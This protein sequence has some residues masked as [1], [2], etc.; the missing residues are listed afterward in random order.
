MP[1]TSCS[2]RR[3]ASDDPATIGL[4]CAFPRSLPRCSGGPGR[5]PWAANCS[6]DVPDQL[7]PLERCGGR[8]HEVI[9]AAHKARTDQ[10]RDDRLGVV[11]LK[12][13]ADI[14]QRPYRR[15]ACGVGEQV[16]A[17][18]FENVEIALGGGTLVM[19]RK[20][21][22]FGVTAGGQFAL[23]P[24]PTCM[25]PPTLGFPDHAVKGFRQSF[26]QPLLVVGLS[27]GQRRLDAI[28]ESIG[29]AREQLLVAIEELGPDFQVDALVAAAR[30]ADARE[31][32]K[33]AVLE[34]EYE[35]LINWMHELAARALAEGQRLGVL[36]GAGGHPWEQLAALGVISNRSAA[37]LQEAKELRDELAHAYPPAGWMALY[38]GIQT[39]L[40][41]L[42]RYMDRCR[43]WLAEAGILEEVDQP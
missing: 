19:H 7:D 13:P 8:K 34:R 14:R 38:E 25:E 28:F 1:M 21:Q 32:N 40:A 36:D 3:T 15:L 11:R 18:A 6:D 9:G 30:S 27:K 31:R 35:V 10:R 43:T 26:R 2:A 37:R 39:L 24:R 4:R 20:G 42:D 23:S 5:T 29:P 17:L 12:L 41:E 33:V 16:D 22:P